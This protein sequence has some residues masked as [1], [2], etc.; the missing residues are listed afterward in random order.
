MGLDEWVKKNYGVT[1][2]DVSWTKKYK[3]KCVYCGRSISGLN[4]VCSSCHKKLNP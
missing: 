1:P 3:N 4:S 2:K